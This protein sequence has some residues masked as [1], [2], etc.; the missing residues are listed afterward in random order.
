MAVERISLFGHMDCAGLVVARGSRLERWPNL[1][2]LS[3]Q[4]PGRQPAKKVCF[5]SCTKSA[6]AK[7]RLAASHCFH[8]ATR[9]FIG[10]LLIFCRKDYT[11][12]TGLILKTLFVAQRRSIRLARSMKARLKSYR[13]GNS[14][15]NGKNY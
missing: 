11:V 9:C 4:R 8:Q 14:F 10:S 2:S 13:S 15:L 12:D 7:A 3:S 5:C 6:E 1:R